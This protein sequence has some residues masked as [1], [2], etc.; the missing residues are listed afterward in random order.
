[1]LSDFSLS[2]NTVGFLIEGTFDKEM[3]SKLI[4][5]IEAKLDFYDTINL[6]LEDVNIQDFS[7]AAVV[8][9]MLFKVKHS[10]RFNKIALVTDKKYFK[11]CATITKMFMSSETRTFSPSERVDAITWVSRTD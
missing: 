3:A 9:E 5:N 11:A 1:M 2:D 6:Y 8:E 10:D 4:A 7:L